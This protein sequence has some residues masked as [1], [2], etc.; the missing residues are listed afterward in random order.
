VKHHLGSHSALYELVEY[1]NYS[2]VQELCSVIPL[3]GSH[4]DISSLWPSVFYTE[5]PEFMP[6]NQD[7]TLALSAWYCLQVH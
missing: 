5:T 1:R 7:L 6:K 3:S 4:C 2:V